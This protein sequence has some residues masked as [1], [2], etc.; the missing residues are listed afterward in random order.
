[1]RRFVGFLLCVALSL[2]ATGAAFAADEPVSIVKA[3]GEIVIDGNIAEWAG[4]PASFTS[5]AWAA[6]AKDLAGDDDLSMFSMF[7]Y[8]ANY[9]YMAFR[10]L[11]DAIVMAR[12]GGDIWQNDCIEV[13]IG[14][15]QYGITLANGADVYVHDWQGGGKD[16]IKAAVVPA[17]YGY[18]VEAAMPLALV[19]SIIGK[20]VAS[21]V[22]FQLSFGAD[23]ADTKGG[24]RE[25]QIYF[26]TGWKW[27]DVSTYA[28]ATFQ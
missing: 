1:M 22:S 3:P 25:G 24:G 28:T 19:E 27:G 15:K 13:W 2:V 23:D 12:S 14:D 21:G 20:K 16:G 5:S 17:G 4:V 9:L 7:A 18:V 6:D 11:D 26:P 8:D 10:V